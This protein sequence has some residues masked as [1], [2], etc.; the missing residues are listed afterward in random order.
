VSASRRSAKPL[1][2]ALVVALPVLLLLSLRVGA[3]GVVDLA[4]ALQACLSLL[5]LADPLPGVHQTILELRLWR[6][7]TTAGVGA[8]LAL[9]G[10]LVQGLFRNGLAAPSVL[11]VTGG[12]SL[13][14]TLAILVLGGS[15]PA[16]M[17]VADSGAATLLVPVFGFVGA[18][19]AVA[20]VAALAAPG[21]RLSVPTLLL[22]GIAVNTCIAGLLSLISSLMLDDWEVSRAILSWTF[23]TLD[24]RTGYHAL[25]V[26]IGLAVAATAIPLVA[27]ELDL[28]QGGED[29]AASLGVNTKRVRVLCIGAASL[30]AAAAVAVAGQIAFVGLVVPHLVRLLAGR[31]HRAL[32]PLSLAGGMAFLL[33]L[34]LANHW[35]LGSS[36]LQPGVAMSLVGGPFFIGL[37]VFNRREIDSW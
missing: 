10:A 37:L 7:L 22:M 11:G 16:L 8:A 21:G 36:A 9:S 32:L 33:A 27:W 29:D 20:L 4:S 13:G 19:A 28:L 6:T 23:G 25:T 24:D 1:A 14:A 30:S 3:T 26:W 34:E 2:Y 31:G 5:G 15:G 17:G 18:L 12:A 35:L